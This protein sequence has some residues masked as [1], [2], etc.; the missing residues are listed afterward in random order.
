MYDTFTVTHVTQVAG[1]QSPSLGTPNVTLQP[2]AVYKGGRH[3]VVSACILAY[4]LQPNAIYKVSSLNQVV[5]IWASACILAYTL[6][7]NAIYNGIIAAQGG[8]HFR[9]CLYIIISKG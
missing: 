4:T 1:Q 5:G 8:R 2:N 9:L 7:P 6:Q 3:L